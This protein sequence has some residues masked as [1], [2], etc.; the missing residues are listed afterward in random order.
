MDFTVKWIIFTVPGLHFQD[1]G[2]GVTNK[3]NVVRLLINLYRTGKNYLKAILCLP[4]NI[5]QPVNI[6]GDPVTFFVIFISFISV[7]LKPVG[8]K[9]LQNLHLYLL[10][11][12]LSFHQMLVHS[13]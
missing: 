8:K 9:L 11:L 7:G 1:T 2:T 3:G 5:L 10:T 6:L 13:H 4:F 12:S